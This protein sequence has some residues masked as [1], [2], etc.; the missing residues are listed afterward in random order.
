MEQ[1]FAVQASYERVA[2]AYAEQFVSELAHKPQDQALL[3]CFV[4]EVGAQGI[5]GDVGRGPSHMARYRHE[6]GL[7]TVG[8]D[9]SAAIVGY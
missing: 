8:L 2:A 5:A 3:D 7:T 6:R 9:L 1:A 4:E